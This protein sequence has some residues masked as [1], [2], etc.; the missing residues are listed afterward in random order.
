MSRTKTIDSQLTNYKTY[1]MYRRQLL[2]LAENV[3]E[4]VNMPKYIDTSF[5]NKNLVMNGSI[6][7]FVDEVMRFTCFALYSIRKT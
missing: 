6:A 4:F 5:L 3:F 1:L 2:S 7:F